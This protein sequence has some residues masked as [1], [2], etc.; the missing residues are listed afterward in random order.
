M[1]RRKCLVP[2]NGIAITQNL[3]GRG[4][5]RDQMG[6]LLTELSHTSFV[7]QEEK[8]GL[9]LFGKASSFKCELN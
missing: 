7:N 2:S 6:E 3:G 5:E 9:S 1:S 4:N 8:V